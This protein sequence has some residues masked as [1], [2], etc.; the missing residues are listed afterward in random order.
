M[1][2]DTQVDSLGSISLT[3]KFSLMRHP[4]IEVAQFTD[5]QSFEDDEEDFDS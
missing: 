1:F 4:Y 3:G 5:D 2:P